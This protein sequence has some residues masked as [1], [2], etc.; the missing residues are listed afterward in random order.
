MLCSGEVLLSDLSIKP[1]AIKR[2][3]Y[4]TAQQVESAL[5]ELAALQAALGLRN[6]VQCLGACISGSTTDGTCKLVIIT[7]CVSPSLMLT[8]HKPTTVLSIAG[9]SMY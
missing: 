1:C 7:E 5:L 6:V 3:K 2:V 9:A 8:D 4:N